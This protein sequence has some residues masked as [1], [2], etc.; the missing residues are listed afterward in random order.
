MFA[1]FSRRDS[2][3]TSV[4]LSGANILGRMASKKL[5][6]LIDEIKVPL[7]LDLKSKIYNS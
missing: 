3:I 4:G 7:I 5:E 2:W 1:P 6:I